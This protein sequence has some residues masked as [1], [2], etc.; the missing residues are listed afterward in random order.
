[1]TNHF[2]KG[3][4]GVHKIEI[5][6]GGDNVETQ[7][8]VYNVICVAA[9]D[10]NNVSLVC[11]NDIAD[12]AINYNT[13]TLFRYATYN[14]TKVTFDITAND[15]NNDFV[16]VSGEEL[17]VQT[18]TKTAY[19]TKLEIETEATD[20]VTLSVRATT[21]E[22]VEEM[23]MEVDNSNSYAAVAGANF[24]TNSSLR[25]N[26]AADRQEIFNIAAKAD[27]TSYAA[28]WTG[29]AW[30]TDGWAMDSDNNKCLVVAAG[31]TVEVPDLKPLAGSNAGS[32]TLEF[33]Y[34]CSNVADY[35]T[36]VMSFMSTDTYNAAETNGIILFPTRLTVLTSGNR[37]MVA[38]T[39]QLVEDQILHVVIVLQ[40]GYGTTGR[41]LCHI[42]VN[43]IRQCVFEYGGNTSFGNGY[44]KMGQKSADFYFYMMRYYTGKVFEAGDAMTNFLNNT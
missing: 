6:M 37:Q 29:F 39:V 14:A 21:G 38:Q 24:Y 25:S 19:T 20:G 32:L 42:Y 11:I 2:P 30:S 26:G 41:N 40:R 33:K 10:A 5:W 18:Q 13:Q 7:H 16:V 34:R 22:H 31:N 35:D 1:M 15:G 43:G 12:K 27:K 8:Y 17:T 3:G 36:P 44:L 9:A 4:T 28:A 23:V